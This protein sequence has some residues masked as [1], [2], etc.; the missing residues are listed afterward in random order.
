LWFYS[1]VPALTAPVMMCSRHSDT[2]KRIQLAE[3][4]ST[5]LMQPAGSEVL[6]RVEGQRASYLSGRLPKFLTRI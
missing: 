3:N 1:R 6:Y 4:T 2:K 5:G